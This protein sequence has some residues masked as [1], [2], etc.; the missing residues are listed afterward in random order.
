MNA[1]DKIFFRT[2]K[3]QNRDRSSSVRAPEKARKHD[4]KKRIST[5]AVPSGYVGCQQELGN[6]V[7]A[8]PASASGGVVHGFGVCAADGRKRPLRCGR[9]QDA[10]TVVIDLL[11][12]YGTAGP[13]AANSEGAAGQRE[14]HLFGVF[15]GHRSDHSAHILSRTF[16]P[17]LA[18]RLHRD[19]VLRPLPPDPGGRGDT[20]AG[21]GQTDAGQEMQAVRAALVQAVEAVEAD[22][23]ARRWVSVVRDNGKNFYPVFEMEVGEGDSGTEQ[24]RERERERAGAREQAREQERTACTHLRRQTALAGDRVVE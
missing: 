3:K 2:A 7:G 9:S 12:H 13:D 17:E 24:E 16:A 20:G 15:D 22:V 19:G 23:C 5:G 14:F 10:H 21:Q 18:K 4:L 8:L 6:I 1:E 11:K